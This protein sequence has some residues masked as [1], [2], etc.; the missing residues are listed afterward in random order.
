MNRVDKQAGFTIIE[1]MLSMAFVA[2]L[3]I[4]IAMT[5]I[6]MTNIYNKGTTLRAVDQAGRAVSQDMQSTIAA[7]QPLD[8]GDDG[9]GGL[10][11]KP[12]VQIGGAQNNPDG[13]RLC[14]G[15]Y[16]YV[17]NTG[18]G[19][20]NPVNRFESSTDQIRLVKVRDTGSLYCNDVT[21]NVKQEDASELLSAGDRELALQSFKILPVAVDATTQQTLYTIGLELGTN[22][23]ASLSQ[24]TTITTI[25]TS[26]KPPSDSQSQRDFCAVNRF[27]FTVR[28]GNRGDK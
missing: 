21:K 12:Q 1:L 5:I 7:S 4:A 13:G 14:T 8:V 25:D 11:Y 27:E 16:S 10:N 22:D 28:A 19:L 15:T 6:Q 23:Q 18:R 26:C 2:V 20:S 24:T 3:M 9:Q 17:W